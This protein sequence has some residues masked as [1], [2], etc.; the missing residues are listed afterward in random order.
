MD[1]E[2]TNSF[3]GLIGFIVGFSL[4]VVVFVYLWMLVFASWLKYDY[5]TVSSVLFALN[6]FGAVFI[7]VGAVQTAGNFAARMLAVFV[8][9]GLYPFLM[10]SS[11]SLYEAWNQPAMS[12]ATNLVG[13][14]RAMASYPIGLARTALVSAVPAVRGTVSGI[15]TSPLM[16]QVVGSSITGLLAWLLGRS[17][18]LASAG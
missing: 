2:S 1:T 13:W 8:W 3:A 4:G 16:T 18:K 12:H 14:Y 7:L 5:V 17:S 6:F 15:E 9:L 10:S 11:L